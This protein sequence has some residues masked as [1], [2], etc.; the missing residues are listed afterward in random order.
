MKTVI[1]AHPTLSE[2]VM[3]AIHDAYDEAI[4]V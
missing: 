3:E 2:T 1:H 4:H